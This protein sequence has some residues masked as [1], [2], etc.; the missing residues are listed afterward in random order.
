MSRVQSAQFLRYPNYY[1]LELGPQ[2]GAFFVPKIK[3]NI[4]DK[5]FYIKIP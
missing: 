1:F 2:L 4:T 5:P 3:N